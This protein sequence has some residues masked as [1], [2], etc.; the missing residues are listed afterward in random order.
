MIIGVAVRKSGKKHPLEAVMSHYF[1][2][3][4]WPIVLLCAAAGLVLVMLWIRQG[5]GRLAVASLVVLAVGGLVFLVESIVTTPAEHGVS[6][7]RG[8][9]R[10][11][12]AGDDDGIILVLDP[13]AS[14]H[15][16]SLENTGRPFDDLEDS[17]RSLKG[18]NRITDNWITRLEGTTVDSDRATV[19]LACL[20]STER[21]YGSVP[22]SWVFDVRRTPQG[23]W[24]VRR[25]AFESLMGRTPERPLR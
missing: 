8:I 19:N 15:I 14:I 3:N 20:T 22:S 11:A 23:D 7:V 25:L 21:S 1:L 6:L 16:G 9:V 5:D 18:S 12:E 2:E 24:L 4:P 13:N 10:M 17:I